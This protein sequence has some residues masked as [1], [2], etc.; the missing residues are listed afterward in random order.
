VIAAADATIV[1][2]LEPIL[3]IPADRMIFGQL[4]YA[5]NYWVR[6]HN[7]I[8][9]FPY[10]AFY[11]TFEFGERRD[12]VTRQ[13][14]NDV[15][16][17]VTTVR[18]TPI[19]LNYTI[20]HVGDKVVDQVN[21]IRRYLFWASSTPSLTFTDSESRE[22]PFAVEFEPPEDNSDLEA[23]EESGRVVRTT[24]TFR[25]HTFVMDVTTA[26]GGQILQILGRVHQYY[27]SIDDSTPII[28]DPDPLINIVEP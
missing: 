9:E 3:G 1:T 20:E 12:M 25:V 28:D 27:D 13:L 24:L 5:R 10:L 8:E 2:G 21:I 26:V 16:G 22:W 15:P 19:I 17:S 4:E 14:R 11:R 6:S 7:G 18:Y 23:E